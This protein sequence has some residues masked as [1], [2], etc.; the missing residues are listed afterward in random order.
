M[1]NNFNKKTTDLTANLTKNVVQAPDFGQPHNSMAG[2]SMFVST[3]S[4]P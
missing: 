3:Q 4:S 2:L 1:Q